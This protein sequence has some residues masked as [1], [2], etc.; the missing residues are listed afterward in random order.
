MRLAEVLPLFTEI[1]KEEAAGKTIDEGGHKEGNSCNLPGGLVKKLQEMELDFSQFSK[2]DDEGEEVRFTIWDF[3][4]QHVYYTSHQTFLSNR[5]IYLLVMDISKPL[6]TVI[7]T[8]DDQH[9]WKDTGSPRTALGKVVH[10][11]AVN[12]DLIVTLTYD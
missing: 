3:G 1:P 10:A 12:A 11:R 7:D 6:N 8:C 9:M 4:G 2:S 5:A